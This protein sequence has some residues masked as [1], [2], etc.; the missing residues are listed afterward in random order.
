MK[1]LLLL[2]FLLNN[3]L[4]FELRVFYDKITDAGVDD[5]SNNLLSFKV[6]DNY[7]E[8]FGK[9]NQ[10]TSCL[11]FTFDKITQ[12]CNLK[13]KLSSNV[14]ESNKIELYV[15][16]LPNAELFMHGNKSLK[17]TIVSP[18]PFDYYGI[19]EIDFNNQKFYYACDIHKNRSK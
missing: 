15:K 4:S 12:M 8:C 2:I 16:R 1:N 9:C 17:N 11:A 19:E 18:E 14:Y 5:S 6:H 3:H 7:L 10:E 13:I